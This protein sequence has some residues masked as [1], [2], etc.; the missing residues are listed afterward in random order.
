MDDETND[1]NEV[2]IDSSW[3]T[4]FDKLENDYAAFYTNDIEYINIHS[5][6]IN[7]INDIEHINEEKLFLTE[8]N[9]I[10]REE[11]VDVIKRNMN[12]Y[13][14]KYQLSSVLKYNI[15]LEPTDIRGFMQTQY[16]DEFLTQVKN[17]DTIILSKTIT[18]FQDL[19]D[20]ILVY[21]EKNKRT[22]RHGTRKVAFMKHSSTKKHIVKSI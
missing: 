12:Q 21:C 3:I 5:I 15:D 4:E 13:K 17:I 8:T 18:M 1:I 9:K 2:I 10:T 19:N 20:I 14:K 16:V 6:Y 7:S 11:L 22:K